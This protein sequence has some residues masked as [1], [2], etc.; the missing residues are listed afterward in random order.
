MW[1]KVCGIRD[2]ATALRVAEMGAD[3]I[4]L[5][6][7]ES[8]PR[9]VTPEQAVEIA[10]ALPPEIARVGVFVNHPIRSIEL[11]AAKCQLSILQLH[12]DEPPSY[13]ADLQRRVPNAKLIRAWRMG[14]DRLD[15]LAAYLNECKQWNCQLV[16]CLIDAQVAGVYGGSG[17]TVPWARLTREYQTEKWPPMVLAGGLNPKNV[18]EA[19]AATHPWGVDVASGVESSPGVK[20]LSLIDEFLRNV[21]AM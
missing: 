15:G 20:D 7:Y 14:R 9:S 4:G 1:V 13:L 21:R 5:N 2:R 16:G 19:I 17:K 10:Q 12:G 8:S 6:F 3:A 18:A 11:I